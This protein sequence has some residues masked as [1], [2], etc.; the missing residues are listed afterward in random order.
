M[1]NRILSMVK[2]LA[3]SIFAVALLTLAQGI[4]RADEVTISGS[5]TGTVTGVPQLTFSGNNFTGTTSLGNGSLSGANSLGSFFLSTDTTQAVAGSFTLNVTFT[6]PAGIAGGQ[7]ST[8]TA[9][10]TGSVSPNIDQGG[11]LVHFNN[12]TQTFTFNNG[13]TSGS[14]T[15]TLADV[16]V[17]T[18]RS[19]LLTAGITGASQTTVPEPATLL[20]LG[21]GLTGVAAGVRRRRNAAGK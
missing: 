18:G 15:L 1:T 14:F 10:I 21:T 9:T 17:Q 11:V 13:S 8:Y 20:L 19:A 2:P 5:T 3:L 16:F 7:G 12:P 4:A 6:A